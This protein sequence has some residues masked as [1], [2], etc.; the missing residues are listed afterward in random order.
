[1]DAS[2]TKAVKKLQKRETELHK[3]FEVAVM[4]EKQEESERGMI[5]DPKW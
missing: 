5:R 4:D 2:G 3:W 1:M